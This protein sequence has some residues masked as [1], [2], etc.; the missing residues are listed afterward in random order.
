MAG[1]KI[2]GSNLARTGGYV[3][4]ATVEE[5][6][7]AGTWNEV[8][9]PNTKLY[10]WLRMSMPD[11]AAM[12]IGKVEF[13][14]GERLLGGEGRGVKFTPF[15]EGQ[16]AVND[17][18][19]G[20]DV[21][22]SATTNRPS[23]APAES[24]L[25]G[26][27][28]LKLG[29][30]RGATIR[31]TLDGSTPTL[32]H[33]ETYSRPIRIETNAT[34]TAIAMA[35]DREPSL[36]VPVT[37]LIKGQAAPG[38]VTAHIGNSL[39][40]TASGFWRYARTAGHAHRQDAFL[41]PGAL[42]RELWAV[43]TGEFREDTI[44]NARELQAQKRGSLTWDAYW[45]KIGK[46]DHLTLQPRDFNLEKEVAAEIQF[47]RKFREK[48]PELQPWLYCE[49]VEM[50]RQRPSDKGVVPSYQME[51]TFPALTWQ[52]SMGAMLLY[53]EELQHRLGAQF[54]EGKPVRI[55]PTALAMGWIKNR[56]DRGEFPG[57]KP[58]SFYPLLFNDQVHPASGPT[59]GG[60]NGA[61]LVDL[62]WY[63]AFY[64]EPAEGKVL[65]VET[66]L[67]PEQARIVERLAW[68]V[69]KN[70]PDCGL[71]EEGTQPCD[72]PEFA[73]D[74]K[75]ITLKSATPGAWFRY[76]LDGTT[77]TRTRGYVYCGAI[78]VQPG[79][80]VKAVAYRSGMAEST[81]AEAEG[82]F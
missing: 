79:I 59:Q 69:V 27:L 66:T 50:K 1:A 39:T 54:H 58:G 9:F 24:D 72:K 42:T 10:R 71:Y 11:G 51:K 63:A 52:E 17:A 45:S 48:S 6:P 68:D 81:P 77:P 61:Y 4:L 28:D 76:T 57:V 31:Y 70:Y 80:R 64:R 49:W 47:L 41:R 7:A 3:T 19:V 34:V 60:A 20:Y 15:V 56:I 23:F 26:P 67:T 53:V 78:S 73:S 32:Q 30:P 21:F 8:R 62:T 65:P 2:E 13:Y 25:D 82:A 74:G 29:G 33:G 22:D 18:A 12:K 40:G 5:T 75:V 36:A 43:A 38:L 35:P 16:D 44:A 14:S 46:V 55:L 37:Y